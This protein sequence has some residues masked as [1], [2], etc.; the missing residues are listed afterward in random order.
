MIAQIKAGYTDVQILGENPKY[1]FRLKDMNLLR[2]TLLSDHCKR[3]RREVMALY[4]FG[5]DAELMTNFVYS[6]HGAE[7]ICR[8]IH[9]KN[10]N[11]SFDSYTAEDVLLLERFRSDIP[12]RDMMNYL[13]S[14][15]IMLPARYVDRVACYTQVYITSDLPPDL[16]Y[17]MG[18]YTALRTN[19][20][21][22]RLDQI[23]EFTEDGTIIEW[24]AKNRIN[25]EDSHDL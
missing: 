18:K 8:I 4:L 3:N 15:P 25:M 12:L 11:I 24:N 19:E 23:I 13:S 22:N 10:K 17:P 5:A 6:K 21:Y 1:A 9:Y 20:F 14:Y 2:Q 16:Q 7:N